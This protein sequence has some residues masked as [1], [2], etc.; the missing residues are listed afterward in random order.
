MQAQRG[1]HLVLASPQGV[2]DC[3]RISNVHDGHKTFIN[4]VVLSTFNIALAVACCAA[5]VLHDNKLVHRDLHLPNEVQL[6]HQQ[7][8][9]I[10]LESVAS[11]AAEPLSKDFHNVL[12][13]CTADALDNA[14]HFTALSDMFCI[15]VLLKET[16]D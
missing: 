1:L 6:G 10:D 2:H 3:N 13:T 14:R 9:L 7:Y 4:L 15:G 12:I 8:M 5:Q 16:V 11:F